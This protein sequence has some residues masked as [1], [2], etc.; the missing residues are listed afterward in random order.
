[1]RLPSCLILLVVFFT[2]GTRG[3]SYEDE[4]ESEIDLSNGLGKNINWTALPEG[5][6][7]NKKENKPL[8]LI[9]H[10]S[11]CPTC[12]AL[13]PKLRKSREFRELSKQF[14]MVNTMDDQE[15]TGEIFKP[16]GGYVPR[17]LFFRRGRLLRN[18][19]NFEGNPKYKYYHHD[20]SSLMKTMN[21]VLRL[22]ANSNRRRRSQQK[23]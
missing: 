23:I 9:I 8:L 11:W 14:I 3:D 10:K 4:S 21:R 18:A 5:L 2:S 7:Q 12:R 20:P 13:A 16:D 17:I 22:Y 15:P 1:M 6:A 19:I